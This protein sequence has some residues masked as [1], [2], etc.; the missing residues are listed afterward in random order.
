[1]SEYPLYTSGN[2]K[3]DGTGAG[4][5]VLSPKVGQEWRLTLASVLVSTHVAEPQCS[6][7]IGGAATP[8]AFVDGTFTGS[9]NSTDAVASHPVTPGQKVIAVWSGGD[10]G[11]TATLTL[12][13]TVVTGRGR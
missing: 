2:V 6:I 9:L 10:A 5:V 3:L 1:M 12:R 11:A 13:G 7:Y 8:D 4:T